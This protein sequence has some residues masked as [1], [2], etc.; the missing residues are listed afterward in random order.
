MA[1]PHVSGAAALL[2]EADPTKKN[3]E[4]KADLRTNSIKGVIEGSTDSGPVVNNFLLYVGSD[5]AP[6]S[7]PTTEPVTTPAPPPTPGPAPTPAPTTPGPSPT[8][9]PAPTPGNC[10]GI[11]TD[12]S[13]C[14]ACAYSS[15]RSD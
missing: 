5:G 6:P 14:D 8:P 9:A 1:C 3:A 2:L 4:V 13:D 7:P 11:C 15:A 12:P 10:F